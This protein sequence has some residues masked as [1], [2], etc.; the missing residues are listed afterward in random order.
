VRVGSP[1]EGGREEGTWSSVEKFGGFVEDHVPGGHLQLVLL[2]RMVEDEQLPGSG[3]LLV[4]VDDG[5]DH[6]GGEGVHV[7]PQD[8]VVGILPEGAGQGSGD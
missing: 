1:E 3:D 2:V 6:V 5:G 4:H 7:H 8:G